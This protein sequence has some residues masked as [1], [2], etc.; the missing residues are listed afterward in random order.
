M[1]KL[2]QKESLFCLYYCKLRNA[3]EAASR[4][5]YHDP[6]RKGNAL[7]RRRDILSHISQIGKDDTVSPEEI[8][9][10]YRRIAFGSC[11][12]ALRLLLC[13]ELPDNGDIESVD[14]FNVSEIK[15]PK[16]GAIEIKFFDRLK[17]LEHLEAL[18]GELSGNDSALSF[19]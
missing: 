12:D 15:K 11:H 2:T 17:A 19:Y 18:S 4:A 9:S 16:D 6:F 3:V 13:G 8:V 10:G 7:L 1:K 14:L 5:G